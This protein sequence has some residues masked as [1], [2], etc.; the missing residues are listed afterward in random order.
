MSTLHSAAV[1]QIR[2]YLKPCTNLFVQDVPV[3]YSGHCNS[4]SSFEV[5]LR[6]FRYFKSFESCSRQRGTEC[7]RCLFLSAG[8]ST[9]DSDRFDKVPLSRAFPRLRF[10]PVLIRPDQVVQLHVL[11]L[12][13]DSSSRFDWI[14]GAKIERVSLR[15]AECRSRNSTRK[16]L[17][18]DNLG[19]VTVQWQPSSLHWFAC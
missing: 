7:P 10:P 12:E 3:D 9:T 18:W 14:S 15:A 1:G 17:T 16:R 11:A 2:A 4:S 19:K 8:L 6:L 5:I 13:L